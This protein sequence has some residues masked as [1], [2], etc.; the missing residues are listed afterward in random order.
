MHHPGQADFEVRQI[1]LCDLMKPTAKLNTSV[2]QN[3]I[4]AP[5]KMRKCPRHL[6]SS[7]SYFPLPLVWIL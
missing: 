6:E 4:R 5:E 2:N 3:E 7:L 1:P